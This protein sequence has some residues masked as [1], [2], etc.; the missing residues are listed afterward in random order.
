MPVSFQV[1]GAQTIQTHLLDFVLKDRARLDC[2]KCRENTH[3]YLLRARLDNTSGEFYR[4]REFK[5]Q[6]RMLV[7]YS[8]LVQSFFNA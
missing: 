8:V 2:E 5:V 3:F 1:T 6:S 7:Y 4:L